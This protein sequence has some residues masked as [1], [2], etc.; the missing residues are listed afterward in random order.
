LFSGFLLILTLDT[1]IS[2]KSVLTGIIQIFYMLNEIKCS[3]YLP[4]FYINILPGWV[5]IIK[6]V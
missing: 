6:I 2:F 4:G 5:K 3:V 1:N